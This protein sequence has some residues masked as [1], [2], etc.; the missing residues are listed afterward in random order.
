M[1][2]QSAKLLRHLFKITDILI[3]LSL[4]LVFVKAAITVHL[5]TIVKLTN[6][7]YINIS[8]PKQFERTT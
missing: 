8:T 5:L 3:Q 7:E 1:L 2:K 6:K 4:L